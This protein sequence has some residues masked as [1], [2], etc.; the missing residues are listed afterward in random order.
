M[1][2][3]VEIETYYP[4]TDAEHANEFLYL[5]KNFRYLICDVIVN[6]ASAALTSQNR[7]EKRASTKVHGSIARK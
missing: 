2:F 4:L 6:S 5:F 1:V 7:P 3:E